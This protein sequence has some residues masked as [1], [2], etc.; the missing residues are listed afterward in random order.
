MDLFRLSRAQGRMSAATQSVLRFYNFFV[1]AFPERVAGVVD[2]ILPHVLLATTTKLL[3]AVRASSV[4]RHLRQTDPNAASLW[5]DAQM[6]PHPSSVEIQKTIWEGAGVL[7]A[8]LEWAAE[9]SEAA[10]TLSSH[11]FDL[12]DTVMALSRYPL[13]SFV[14]DELGSLHQFIGHLVAH[15]AAVAPSGAMLALLI[16]AA[17]DALHGGH[18]LFP[19]W[20]GLGKAIQSNVE[21]IEDPSNCRNASPAAAKLHAT[22]FNQAVSLISRTVQITVESGVNDVT[23]YRFM[24]N[25]SSVIGL[26]LGMQP[27]LKSFKWVLS[28]MRQLGSDSPPAHHAQLMLAAQ[29]LDALHTEVGL[30]FMTEFLTLTSAS[31]ALA[32]TAAG[33]ALDE[34][35]IKLVGAGFLRLVQIAATYDAIREADPDDPMATLFLPLGDV[36]LRAPMDYLKTSIAKDPGYAN[37]TSL[38]VASLLRAYATGRLLGVDTVELA[39]AVLS[40]TVAHLPLTTDNKS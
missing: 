18:V 7:S 25:I 16:H 30:E 40:I 38:A 24:E 21:L 32:T 20:D 19:A 5:D 35:T 23:L 17:L 3:P 27:K 39:E 8:L 34:M 9:S 15:T 1:T 2:V 14:Q 6:V 31:A 37:T 10:A 28:K 36:L 12:A 29:I 22:F 11:A 26:A 13:V 33:P 4:P